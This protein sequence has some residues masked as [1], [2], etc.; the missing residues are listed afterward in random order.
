MANAPLVANAV[1]DE[2]ITNV[3]PFWSG[4]PVDPNGGFHGAIG[5]DGSIDDTAERT[6]V[7]CARVLWA[8]ST[9][10]QEF[11]HPEYLKIADHAWQYL[12]EVLLDEEFGGLYWSAAADGSVVSDRKHSYAQSFGIYGLVAYAQASGK[13]EPMFL[14]RELY[15]LL[16]RHTR[17]AEH[18][19]YIEAT[20]R[21]WSAI[22]DMRLSPRDLQAP[23]SMNTN[24]HVME[25]Y[26]A[27]VRATGDEGV[28]T[29]L[30]DLT[31]LML[32]KVLAKNEGAFRLFFDLQWRPLTTAVSFG[33][34][35]EGAWLLTDAAQA[36]GDP[37]LIARAEREAVNLAEAVLDHGLD[38]EGAVCYQ[39]EPGI[40][41]HHGTID[42]TSHWW[43]Q[44]EGMVGFLEAERITGHEHFRTAAEAC[45]QVIT[46]HH[47]DRVGGD[48]F[49]VLD[50]D[51]NPIDAYPKAG[52]WECPYHHVRALLEVR[53][54]LSALAVPLPA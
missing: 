1:L 3:L 10:A 35:I 43:A 48:W 31:G 50:A 15:D 11:N 30:A 12:R 4:L 45:W 2:L 34:D 23:K 29:S 53:R 37:E 7:L 24:L 17:D 5:N 20:A 26:A 38:G 6:A 22:E 42:T 33:H 46:T 14:A 49:K 16:E 36:V 52:P 8:F 18:G 51:R 41:H 32:D 21:D 40:G 39:Y 19:G 25:A 28:R 27:L 54:R 44:C 47:I 13:P 9:V